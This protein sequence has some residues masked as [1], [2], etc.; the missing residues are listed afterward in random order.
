[1]KHGAVNVP[2]IG[3]G[4]LFGISAASMGDLDG[5]GGSAGAVAVG[6]YGD[7]DPSDSGAVYILYLNA[8]GT[9]A[10]STKISD[11]SGDPGNHLSLGTGELFGFSVAYLGDYDG[12][13]AVELAVGA[14]RT[15]IGPSNAGSIR[16][17]DINPLTGEIVDDVRPVVI[18]IASGSTNFTTL[19]AR[20]TN[21]GGGSRTSAT[22]TATARPRSGPAPWATT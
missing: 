2:G 16:I 10:G 4:D 20:V 19:S 3:S 14:R 18:T 7:D 11:I 5:P 13:G 17:L 22:G 21:S 1:M 8:D 6:S 15:D 12:D 9:L